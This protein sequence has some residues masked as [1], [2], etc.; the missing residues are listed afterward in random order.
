[1]IIELIVI[2]L[3]FLGIAAIVDVVALDGMLGVRLARTIKSWF[4]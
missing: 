1:M 4:R 3:L 2:P